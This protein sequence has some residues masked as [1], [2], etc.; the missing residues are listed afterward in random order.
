MIKH[1]ESFLFF[2]ISIFAFLI[3]FYVGSNGV[4][5]VDTF[6]HYDYGYRIL[7]GDD[8]IKDYWIVHGLMIDYLQSLFFLIFGNNWTSYLIHSSLLNVA[9]AIFTIYIFLS[10]KIKFEYL[11]IISISISLLAYPVSGSPFLDLHSSFFSLFAFNFVILWIIKEKNYFWFFVSFF[12]C[13]AFFSK[14]VP[15]AYFIIALSVLNLIYAI[16]FKNL[17]II[18][19]YLFGVLAFFTLFILFLI[20]RGVNFSDLILQIFLFPQLIGVDRYSNYVLNFKNTI[21]E[22][23]FIHI[24]FF[25]VIALNIIYSKNIKNYYMSSEF[26]I[27]IAVILFT[28]ANIVHQIYTKNQIYIFFLIPMLVGFLIYFANS[29]KIKNKGII[30]YSFLTLCIFS[31][32]KYA[33]RYNID[34]KFHELE[35]VKKENAIKINFLNSKLTNLKWISPYFKDPDKELKNIM[36]LYEVLKNDHSNKML[37]TEYN[38]FSSL[39]EENL[40]SPSRTFDNISYPKKDTKYFKAYKNFFIKNIISKKIE[41]IYVFEPNE[42]KQERLNH[43]VFNYIS[44]NCFKIENVNSFTKKLV[45]NKCYE[46]KS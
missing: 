5:P 30:V 22:Y 21:F 25:V 3:N 13:L 26:K 42:I 11:I 39:L 24:P 4:Y 33:E 15:A 46:L 17:K 43:L 38:F 27:L 12:L 9:I 2:L 35:Y 29:L 44:E 7:L 32:I 18:Y 34:R 28:I 19:F 14:Q 8:P 10:L 40:N 16:S 23:K 41:N 31:T 1:K 20:F 6:L 36:N 37:I 45:I